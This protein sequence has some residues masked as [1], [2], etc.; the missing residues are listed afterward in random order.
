VEALRETIRNVE[1]RSEGPE[2]T[3]RFG[4]RRLDAACNEAA[5]PAGQLDGV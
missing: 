2:P 4:A 3:K 5:A 1:E